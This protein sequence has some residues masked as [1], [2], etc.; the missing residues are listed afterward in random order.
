V[1]NSALVRIQ[2]KRAQTKEVSAGDGDGGSM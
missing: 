2:E 1:K